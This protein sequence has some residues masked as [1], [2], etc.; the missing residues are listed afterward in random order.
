MSDDR[1]L[2]LEERLNR[3]KALGL[4]AH[5]VAGIIKQMHAANLPLPLIGI[6]EEEICFTY[7]QDAHGIK[8]GVHIDND[9]Q[10][11]L[12][13]KGPKSITTHIESIIESALGLSGNA[14]A[15]Q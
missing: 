5:P 9:G 14:G 6:N 7:Y 10:Y 3:L 8:G 11:G 12:Y 4:E 15:K 13:L 2:S 1:E